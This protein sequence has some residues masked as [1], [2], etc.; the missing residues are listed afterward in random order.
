[1]EKF[2]EEVADRLDS[3]PAKIKIDD[4]IS[5]AHILD[6]EDPEDDDKIVFE[7]DT[8][9]ESDE[10]YTEQYNAFIRSKFK[11]QRGGK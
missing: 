1:M 5:A 9:E 3:K 11:M 8:L 4:E 2:D 7:C 6:A 10:R